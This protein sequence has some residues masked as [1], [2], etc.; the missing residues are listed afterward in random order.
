M[1]FKKGRSGNP[2]G[3]PK[4]ALNKLPRNLVDRVLEI[5]ANL[6]EQGKGL[7]HCAEKDPKWFFENFVKPMIPKN[8]ALDRSEQIVIKVHK[9]PKNIPE[10]NHI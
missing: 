7:Q 2:T 10:L 1:G 9:I 6:E 5:T 4:E 8:I 3:R